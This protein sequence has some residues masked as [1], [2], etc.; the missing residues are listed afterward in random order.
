MK[1][2]LPTVLLAL[3]ALG[4]CSEPPAPS[5]P[6]PD[7]KAEAEL[8]A[9]VEAPEPKEAP[10]PQPEQPAAAPAERKRVGIPA[11]ILDTPWLEQV[12]KQ[13]EIDAGKMKV[14]HGFRFEDRLPESGITF[15]HKVVEDAGKAYKPVHYDHGNGL[16]VADVD[17]DGRLDI[18]FSNQVGA[19]ALWRNLGG[20]R[21]EDWTEK[22]GVGVADR[23]GVSASFA[24]TDND[25]DADLFVTT[26]RGGN[27]L[28][29]NDGAGRFT[30]ITMAS[31]LDYVGH[32]SGAVFFD[33]NRDGLLDLFLA[34][35]GVYST[36]EIGPDDYY[37]GYE[38]AFAN[39][40][41][42]ER[43][44]RS[45][46]YRNMGGNVFKDVS[47]Q[48][49]LVDAS[50]NGDACPIDVNGDGW[51][52]LY[53]LSMQGHDSYYE[54]R[55]G[56]QFVDRSREVFPA[57]SWGAMGIEVLDFENDGRLDIFVTDMHSDMW[58]PM[59]FKKYWPRFE[60]R[61][62][63]KKHVPSTRFLETDGNHVHGNAFFRNDGEGKYT[64]V[65]DAISA[66][67]YWPWGLSVADLNADGYEDAF[68]ASSMNFPYR[69]GPNSVLLNDRGEKFV[70]AAFTLGVEPRRDRRTAKPWFDLDCS[71]AD[72]GHRFC[73]GV[74]GP[75][76]IWGALGSRSSVIFDL[77]DD[78][79]LDIVTNDFNSEPMVLVSNLSQKKPPRWI[80]VALRGRISNRDGLGARIVV[81]TDTATLTRVHDGKSGYL[82]QS[83][84]PLYVGLGDAKEIRRIEIRWPSDT[85]QTIEGPVEVGRRHLFEEPEQTAPKPASAIK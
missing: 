3:A 49:G 35:V 67:N 58:D 1:N 76:A 5:A 25:G 16:A 63:R 83:R 50:W 37:I 32:S 9:P 79:D 34:N 20:G 31:V 10:A 22:A 62:A 81:T 70:E 56:E 72:E 7:P 80:E 21:F 14:F 41:V 44:E 59:P 48:T 73:V 54:N 68:L 12:Q 65:S 42:P 30:D 77:D 19:N 78:G 4:G 46:L 17:G 64:E 66:E 51:I 28:F 84:T 52:D 57:T 45:I 71:G 82:S 75:V 26:V 40:L 61:K 43:S 36:D 60:K 6:Q 27:L 53:V 15:V 8:P 85:T 11:E 47:K 23:I 39:H 13:Q 18:Y 24:D 38:E 74:V 2:V 55:N 69:Y 29:R 33:Y